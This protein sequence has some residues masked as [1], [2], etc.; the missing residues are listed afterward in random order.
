MSQ[1]IGL[2]TFPLA[3]VAL[4]GKR[5]AYA[6]F[7]VVAISRIPAHTGFRLQ[8]PHCEGVSVAGVALS[9]T[10]WAHIMLFGWFFL[11]T[12]AQFKRRTAGNMAWALIATVVMGL[13]IELEEGAARTGNCAMRD[14]FP[15]LAGGLIG[16]ALVAA[17]GQ[18]LARRRGARGDVRRVCP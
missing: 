18:R 12:A 14:L 4:F 3:V 7:L 13:V 17:T 11:L 6:G 15:D 16:W 2:V 8:I 1:I 5:W 9:M 10:K